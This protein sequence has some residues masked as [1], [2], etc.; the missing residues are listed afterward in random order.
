LQGVIDEAMKKDEKVR[1]AQEAYARYK[2][3]WKAR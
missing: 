1:A 3:S 2:L